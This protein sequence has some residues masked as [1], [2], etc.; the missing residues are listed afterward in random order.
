MRNRNV[1]FMP[2]T[3]PPF[4]SALSFLTPPIIAHERAEN[5]EQSQPANLHNNG[6]ARMRSGRLAFSL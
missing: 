2:D 4:E 5:T 3:Q 1:D 6:A